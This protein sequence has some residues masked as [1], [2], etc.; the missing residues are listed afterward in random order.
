MTVSTPAWFD[1]VAPWFVGFSQTGAFKQRVE[2]FSRA[3]AGVR[4]PADRLPRCLDL[5]CGPGELAVAL[6]AQGFEVV[7]IDASSEMLRYARETAARQALAVTFLQGDV[8]AEFPVLGFSPELIV[9]SSVLEYL[10]DPEVVIARSAH[11]LAAGGLLL[12]S[13]PNPKSL[14]R[15]EQEA[16]YSLRRRR[17]YVDQQRSLVPHTELARMGEAAGLQAIG[18]RHFSAPRLLVRW[19]KLRLVGTLTLVVF[20]KP[21]S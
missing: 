4:R 10:E 9:C 21:S 6:A 20:R 11:A 5:G 3:A 8:T 12:V 13:I 2:A 16:L 17:T 1:E 15:R 7:G 19:S 14:P 18:I